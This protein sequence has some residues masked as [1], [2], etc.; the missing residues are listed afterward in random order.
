MRARVPIARTPRQELS[1]SSRA[2]A[3]RSPAPATASPAWARR[4]GGVPAGV[5]PLGSL[6]LGSRAKLF[7]LHSTWGSSRSVRSTGDIGS[8]YCAALP[9]IRLHLFHIDTGQKGLPCDASGVR[10]D[11][12]RLPMARNFHR[13][14]THAWTFLPYRRVR[15]GEWASCKPRLAWNCSRVVSRFAP[16]C[17]LTES[18]NVA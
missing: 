4:R 3:R 15:C 14:T 17:W 2:C 9:H 7:V 6:V 1:G 8:G 10:A 11:N 5:C 13:S 16:V 18:P 12:F